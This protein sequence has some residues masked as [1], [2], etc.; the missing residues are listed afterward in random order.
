MTLRPA[1]LHFHRP[2][3]LQAA[4]P[5]E[6]RGAG[7]DDVRLL[8]STSEGHRHLPFRSLPEVLRSGDV[9]VA[10]DSATI[11]ASLPADGPTG[12]FRLHLATRYGPRTW[13]AEP[14]RTAAEPGPL[15]LAPGAKARVGGVPL[16]FVAPYPGLPRLWFVLSGAPL[17]PVMASVGAP[18]RY[19][20]VP[21]PVPLEAY[22]TV[23]ARTPGSA[24]M[25][26][27]GRP[28][29]HDLVRALAARGVGVHTLTLHA[30]VSSLE[31]G[32]G[33]LDQATLFPEPFAVPAGTAAALTH[34]R[35]RG[36]RVIAIGTTV[37]RALE[38]VWD[39]RAYR[40]LGG[41]TRRFVRPGRWHGSVDGLLTGLHDP[42]ASHLALLYAVAGPTLV[43]D[44]YAAAVERGY[45][46]HEF[47][48]SH[49]LLPAGPRP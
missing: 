7:R 1:D 21:D 32:T 31:L 27:A 28:F 34:A 46:W 35:R 3:A 37:V 23:F 6:A 14:R 36:G 29:T 44:A 24:E 40:P 25:P 9:L 20:Y 2:A 48:D 5:P 16:R 17:E 12:P 13:L 26:S 30:G 38:S 43:R 49:L 4:R 15:P 33:D 11:P 41:F 22:Q 18:I 47:G 8:V 10:N 19:R 42:G 45:L 39:G